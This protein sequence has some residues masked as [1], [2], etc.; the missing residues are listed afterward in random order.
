VPGTQLNLSGP[1]RAML[2]AP[3]RIARAAATVMLDASQRW[4]LRQPRAIRQS[5]V[6]EVITRGGGDPIAQER[7]MLMQD[8][9]VRH[10]Y[11]RDV[12]DTAPRSDIRDD[13]PRWPAVAAGVAAAVA[14][15]AG[16]VY[17]LA[18]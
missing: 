17:L 5:F 11:V 8:D 12:L 10:S 6:A 13:E 16:L 7:W 4:I 2:V 9:G 1:E 14:A 3:D 18:S 15:V